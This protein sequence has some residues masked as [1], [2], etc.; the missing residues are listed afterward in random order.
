MLAKVFAEEGIQVLTGASHRERSTYADG[1]FTVD[2][3]DQR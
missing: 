2:L 3:G 1:Q